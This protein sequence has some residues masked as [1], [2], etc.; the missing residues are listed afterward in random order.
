[1]SDCKWAGSDQPRVLP[2][3]HVDGCENERCQGCVPCPEAHCCVCGKEHTTLDG[4]GADL[5]CGLCLAAVRS[6]LDQIGSLAARMLEEAIVKGINSTAAMHAGPVADMEAWSNRKVSTLAGRIDP[7]WLE[8]NHDELHPTW[9]VGTWEMLIREHLDQPSDD[10]VTLT[11]ARSYLGVHLT[12][13]AHDPEFAFEELARDIR[14]CR[15]HLEDV[16]HDGE[17]ETYGAPCLKCEKPLLRDDQDDEE[18]W[19]CQRC[20][21]RSNADQYRLAVRAGY[22]AKASRLPVVDLAVR[23]G[24][25]ASTLRRWAGVQRKYVGDEWVESPPLLHWVGRDAQQRKV[26]NVAD[27]EALRDKTDV[28]EVA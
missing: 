3:R 9:V 21:R 4:V 16:L 27:A 18:S 12:R 28:G 23:V 20:K 11:E 22:V 25:T 2:Q 7:A 14:K 19:W 15:G 24:V 5:T 17:R 10:K 8:D 6:D 1:M 26:Y 13:L